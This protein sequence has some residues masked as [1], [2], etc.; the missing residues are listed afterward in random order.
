MVEA[1][2]RRT[3]GSETRVAPLGPGLSEQTPAGHD[4]AR[5]QAR[6]QEAALMRGEYRGPLHGIP[7]GIK[8]NLATD[9]FFE[10]FY[11]DFF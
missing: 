6:E 2:N 9:Q 10:S 8:D 3:L 5:I 7:V 11:Y 4:Q 1:G